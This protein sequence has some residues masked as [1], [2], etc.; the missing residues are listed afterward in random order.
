MSEG[1]KD[2]HNSADSAA[3]PSSEKGSD[4]LRHLEDNDSA[5]Q[6]H[7]LSTSNPAQED[8][9]KFTFWMFLACLVGLPIGPLSIGILTF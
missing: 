2:I 3:M 8:D 9:F 1:K 6:P 7:T 5:A 4:N